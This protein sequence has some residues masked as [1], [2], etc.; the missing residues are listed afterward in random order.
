M[1]LLIAYALQ[2]AGINYKWGGNNAL[3]GF[4]CSGFVQELLASVGMDPQGRDTA[5]SLYNYFMVKGLG[6][7]CVMGAIA[8][9]GKSEKEISHVALCIDSNRIIEA[10]GGDS[11]TT[12]KDVAAKQSAQIRIRPIN[13]RSDLIE[14]IIPNYPAWV[15]EDV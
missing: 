8:F 10:G 6:C 15:L 5:Q 9:Y 12:S 11:R 7:D 4:D 1:K 13:Y 3:E 14:V 2:F